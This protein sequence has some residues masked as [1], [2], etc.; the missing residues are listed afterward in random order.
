M[1]DE[2]KKAAQY[3]KEWAEMNQTGPAP[4][5]ND[6]AAKKA[7]QDRKKLEDKAYEV[8]KQPFVPLKKAKGG[9]ISA[10]KRADGIAQR[11]KT[12]A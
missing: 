8:S 2:D 7:E 11:G 12:R 5:P 9:S 10:S 4:I 6:V 3:R 1:A